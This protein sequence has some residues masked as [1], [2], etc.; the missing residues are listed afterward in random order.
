MID[1]GI[2]EPDPAQVRM[3]N[4]A[5]RCPHNY[6]PGDHHWFGCMGVDPF[7]YTAPKE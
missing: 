5:A 6:E 3:E 1:V 4:L 2:D 7:T